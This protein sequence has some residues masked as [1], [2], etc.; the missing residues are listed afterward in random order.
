[1]KRWVIAVSGMVCVV[2]LGALAANG[3]EEKVPAGKT[4]FLTYKCES[5]HSV[6]AA[7]IERKSAAEA[8]GPGAATAKKKTVDLSSTGLDVKAEWLP[9][10]LQKLETTKEGKKHI[11]AWKGTPE[12]LATLSAW[13]MEQKAPKEKAE[14]AAKEAK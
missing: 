5:C 10:Y 4:L 2:A 8:E 14:G 12:E 1:M 13:L 9:K 6:T 3:A 7:G 11:K